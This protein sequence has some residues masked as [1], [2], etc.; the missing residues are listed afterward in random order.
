MCVGFVLSQ[1]FYTPSADEIS[2]G[3]GF[4]PV[5]VIPHYVDEFKHKLDDVGKEFETLRIAEYEFKVLQI[6]I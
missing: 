2:P 3:L 6:D 4:V 1:F 5:K